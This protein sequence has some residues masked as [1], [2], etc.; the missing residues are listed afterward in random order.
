MK[1]RK[2]FIAGI[3][4]AP[5]LAPAMQE[6]P[7][8]AEPVAVPVRAEVAFCDEPQVRCPHCGSTQLHSDRRGWSLITGFIG[9]GKI[10]I[11]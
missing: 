4:Q 7:P 8:V 1:P 2:S 5:A 6:A 10:F 3:P 9:S 11:T